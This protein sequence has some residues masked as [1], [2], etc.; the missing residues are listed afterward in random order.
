MDAKPDTAATPAPKRRPDAPG[1]AKPRNLKPLWQGFVA[2]LALSV[3]AEFAVHL[4]PH[5]EV[6]SLFG[7]SAWFG[8]IACAA[9][10]AL[11]MVLALLLGRPD[12]HYG[13]RDD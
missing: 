13:R 10:I 7:F 1:S 11:A 2:V 9:M 6:E 3:L 5:F 8:F 12:S 4:H